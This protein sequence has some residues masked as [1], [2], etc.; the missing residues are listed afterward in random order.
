MKMKGKRR[1]A[2]FK[3]LSLH[4]LDGTEESSL[5]LDQDTRYCGQNSNPAPPEQKTETLLVEPA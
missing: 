4:L 2:M 1:G 3:F 5:N